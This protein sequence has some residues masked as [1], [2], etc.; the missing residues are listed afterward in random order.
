MEIA[1][2]EPITSTRAL[3]GPY[4]YRLPAGMRDVAVGSLVIVPFANRR[5]LGVVVD[6]AD[7]SELP[8][9]RLAEPIE[10]LEAGTPAELVRLGLWVAERYCSTASRGLALVLPPGS[11]GGARPRAAR[12][13]T[14]RR[15]TITAA[16]RAAL[17]GEARLGR[18]QRDA[19]ERLAAAGE[20][21][22][23]DLAA[24]G[25][26]AGVMRRLEDRGW[27]EQRAA[28]IRRRPAIARRAD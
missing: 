22:G 19:L 26:G 2:V 21:S 13:R 15:A 1:K 18:R 9:E 16:G 5:M 27:V 24:A 23:A 20:L 25:A 3:R 12:A 7:R 14:E 28:E 10:A 4:D 6:L 17:S 11:A 8:P